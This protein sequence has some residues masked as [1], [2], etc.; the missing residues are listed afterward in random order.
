VAHRV[1]KILDATTLSAFIFEIK[2]LDLLTKSSK[3]YDLTTSQQVIEEISVNGKYPRMETIKRLVQIY[4]LNPDA[5]KL[6][7]HLELRFPALHRGELSS[8]II[9]AL[10]FSVKGIPCYYVTDDKA[11]RKSIGKILQDGLFINIVG[12]PLEIKN[13]GT[14]GLLIHLSERSC[15]DK[16]EMT[17]VAHDLE[18]ST[19][20]CPPTLLAKLRS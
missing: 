5:K 4:E 13:T 11:M 6:L 10:E 3:L 7:D 2:G 8:F 14:I 20:R 12:K 15:L 16:E 17:K 9:A 19:F 1:K 18:N